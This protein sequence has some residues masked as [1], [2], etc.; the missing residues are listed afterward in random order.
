MNSI[1]K[2]GE[3]P[4]N[5]K[6]EQVGGKGLNL[7]KLYYISK[8]T[9]SFNVPEFFIIPTTTEKKFVST[10][11]EFYTHFNDKEIER[12][13]NQLGKPVAVRSSSPLEDGINASFAGMFRSFL[14][15]NKYKELANFS[16]DIFESAWSTRVD[17]YA[18]KM[19]TEVSEKMAIIVQEQV[20]N[21][22][23][24]GI[25]QLDDEFDFEASF[26]CEFKDRNG[27]AENYDLRFDYLKTLG[28]KIIHKSRK[29]I[30][31]ITEGDFWALGQ[32]A[33]DAKNALNLDGIIQVE[34]CFSPDKII[35]LVQIRQLPKRQ[36]HLAELDM[37]IPE[38]V[39]Y[40]ESNIC[41]DIAGEL[42]LPAYVT[43]SQSGLE[44]ILIE[45][46][47]AGITGFGSDDER[48]EHF[49]QNSKLAQ[50]HDYKQFKNLVSLGN[51]TKLRKLLPY[52]DETWKR[53]NDLF[54]NYILVCD[55]LD[56]KICEMADVTTNKRAI[57]TCL[58][59]EKTSHAMTVARDLG[60]MC[61]GIEGDTH[62]LEP[63]FFHQIETG[64]TIRMKSNGRKALA[65][66]EKKREFDPYKSE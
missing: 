14:D 2:C 66:I 55:K 25:V 9:D 48:A 58:E 32:C 13:F 27:E 45:T 60:I 47:Q 46:G 5:Y 61:M 28:G 39:P 20:V 21:P 18:E 7:L 26:R 57:I 36:S 65:Y 56:E 24:K 33:I 4:E 10:S 37:D 35:D 16:Y 52:Y 44:G 43:I 29:N 40:I 42:I 38:G 50:N 23:L 12:A 22:W 62:D 15:I 11:D 41:N 3:N 31:R 53:G 59:A 6:V 19:G 63:K 34:A 8:Q 30:K 64:D 54:E 51:L 17:R 49:N 1:I